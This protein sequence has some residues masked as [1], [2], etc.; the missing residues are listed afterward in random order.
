MADNMKVNGSK[1]PVKVKVLKDIPIA[2][3]ITDNS[4]MVEH[5]GK[6]SILG[7][8]EKSMT[9]NGIKDWNKATAFGKV[10]R[11][12]LTLENGRILRHMDMEFTNGPMAIGMKGSGKT[13]LN[14]VRELTRLQMANII[15][16][17]TL[18]ER[19]TERVSINGQVVKSML[20][21]FKM[22]SNMDMVSGKAHKHKLPV[23][24]LKV[25]TKTTWKMELDIILG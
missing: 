3:L 9:A 15:M 16:E 20:V 5:M 25:I 2:I 17:N 7:T 18:M 13:A 11:M 24:N 14:M 8:T 21:T 1:T 22:D 19:V 23:T 12:T 10:S 6:E 4:N